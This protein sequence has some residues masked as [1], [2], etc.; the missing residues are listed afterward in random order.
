MPLTN[1][2]FFTEL[3]FLFNLFSKR[4]G[5]IQDSS[6]FFESLKFNFHK[7]GQ[8]SNNGI[9]KGLNS[10]FLYYNNISISCIANKYNL[11]WVCRTFKSDLS[12]ATMCDN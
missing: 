2:L 1:S 6:L 5:F 3:L 4:H 11:R 8:Q 10:L 7:L 9:M 12:S